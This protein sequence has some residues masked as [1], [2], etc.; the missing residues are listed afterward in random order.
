MDG[1]IDHL[2]AYACDL[3]Y[4]G[5][6]AEA[7]HQAKRTLVDTLGCGIGALGSEPASIARRAA[8][9][10]RGTP[11]ARLLGAAQRTSTDL[12]AFANTALSTATTPTP[13]RAPVIRAT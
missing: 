4:D 10:V 6:S 8:S 2:S 5:L 9:R 11:A 7:V 13:R 1:T 12:A 3:T